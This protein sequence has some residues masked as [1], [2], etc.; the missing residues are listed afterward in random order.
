MAKKTP[1]KGLSDQQQE[2]LVHIGKMMGP[3][4]T[5][6]DDRVQQLHDEEHADEH[7]NTDY[8]KE[9]AEFPH[10]ASAVKMRAAQMGGEL[11][12]TDFEQQKMKQNQAMAQQAAGQQAQGAQQAQAQ[13]QGSS[14]QPPP[15]PSGPV[16][17]Q[18]PYPAQSGPQPSPDV[19]ALPPSQQGTPP[20]PD[21]GAPPGAPTAA[22]Q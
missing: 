7:A 15:A 4:A 8:E 16:G 12:P 22:N 2:A 10:E 18:S 17:T 5:G 20:P 11:G 1:G 3:H 9:F 14:T 6:F 19:T 21:Q 13:A